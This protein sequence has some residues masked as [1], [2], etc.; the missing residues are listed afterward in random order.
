MI[1]RI[2]PA[3]GHYA[4]VWTFADFRY[5]SMGNAVAEVSAFFQ[6]AS[7]PGSPPRILGIS[8]FDMEVWGNL[9]CLVFN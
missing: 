2:L 6:A 5:S 9:Q 7:R 8:R 1:L 4:A 3:L